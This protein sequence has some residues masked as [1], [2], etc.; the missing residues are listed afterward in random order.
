VNPPFSLQRFQLTGRL[1]LL[2]FLLLVSLPFLNAHHRNPI[3]SFYAE[4]WAVA[5][6]LAA[7]FFLLLRPYRQSF[8]LPPIALLPALLLT[9]IVVQLLVQPQSHTDPAL[10]AVLYLLWVVLLMGVA[11]SFLAVH[12]R[13]EVS[14]TLAIGLVLGCLLS[15]LVVALQLS[16]QARVIPGISVPISG[17]FYANLNQPNHLALQL[18]L[19]IAATIYLQAR[20]RIGPGVGLGVL[21]ILVAASLLTGSRALWLYAFG[22]VVL[23]ALLHARLPRQESLLKGAGV[24]LLMTILGNALLPLFGGLAGISQDGPAG[25]VRPGSDG[26]RAGVWW[27]ALKM[28]LENPLTGIGWAAFSGASYT[29][30]EFLQTIAP[31]AL[32][33][34]PAENAH[35][36]L[37]HLFAELGALGPLVLL[38]T[39]LAWGLRVWRARIDLPVALALCVLLL[40]ALHAQLEYTLWYAFFLG[41]AAIFLAIGDPGRWRLPTLKAS[42]LA[43]VLIAGFAVLLMLRQDYSR[44]EKLMHWPLVEAGET[45]QGWQSVMQ[46]MLD[47]RQRSQ[48]GEYVNLALV[49][50]MSID[51]LALDDKLAVC[52]QALAFSPTH[53]AVFKC[54]ALH[55][56]A[57]HH[58]L[59]EKQLALALAAYPEHVKN[60]STGFAALKT[61]YPELAPLAELAGRKA[62]LLTP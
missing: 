17:R 57:G 34:F 40:L 41:I 33:L 60:A 16:G 10:L 39:S 12:G 50:A 36:I 2:P 35:N 1:A 59:A 5:C 48:F 56:L 11:C 27:M 47:L 8:A 37:L 15:A 51:R 45:P 25:W 52:Q 38:L 26:L 9:L 4:W 28:G 3:P 30:I 43:L 55:A 42:S 19:G 7:G 54:A 32:V 6:G 61:E 58:A 24:A 13:Q 49:G 62:S 29:R 23:A 18:W 53:Y 44:L 21:A 31:Q 22:L 20:Q 14:D 46:E